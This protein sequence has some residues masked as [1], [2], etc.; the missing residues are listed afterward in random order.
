MQNQSELP[1]EGFKQ[2][3]QEPLETGDPVSF[4]RV[5]SIFLDTP[6]A[7]NDPF[8]I[9]IQRLTGKIYRGR[10]AREHW[11]GI[12]SHK[13]NMQAKLGRRVSINVT[14]ADYFEVIGNSNG[15]PGQG[16]GLAGP[17]TL[18]GGIN[19][20]EWINRIYAPGHH[21]EKLKEEM[22]RA[23]RYQH[24][25]SAILLD[26][27]EFHR[28]NQDFSFKVGDEILTVIV[29]IIKKII[30]AVDILTRYSGDRF[31]LILPNTNKREASE[32]A[33]RLRSNIQERTKRIKG[34]TVG[35]TATLAVGQSSKEDKSAEFMKSL[36]NTLEEG[37]K[38]GRNAVYVCEGCS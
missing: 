29:K 16:S 25:L 2:F 32:L 35:V 4:D 38:K 23:K 7:P 18:D 22:L 15:R 8:R 9:L 1:F 6:G 34:L 24:A 13:E 36:E 27:D 21:V 5:K 3:V 26:V 10:E 20:E 19:R 17:E 14:A 37:K 33:E 30:R 28:I 12:L 11:Q 31:L